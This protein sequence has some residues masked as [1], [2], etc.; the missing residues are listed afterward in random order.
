MRDAP[1]LS[2][3]LTGLLLCVL[4]TPVVSACDAESDPLAVIVAEETRG[5]LALDMGVPA[6]PEMARRAEVADRLDAP[7]ESW[8]SS[9]GRTDAEGRRIRSR[10]YDEALPVLAPALG[11]ARIG[12][13]L[14]RLRR[15]VDAAHELPIST[16]PDEFRD[17]IARAD[18]LAERAREALEDGRGREAL[19]HTVA[20][21]DA[22]RE[23][24][25]RN[26]ALYLVDRAEEAAERARSDGIPGAQRNTRRGSRMALG[27]REALENRDYP[28]AI[29]RA[30][31][32]CHLLGLDIGL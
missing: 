32:A 7:L 1:S 19:R 8:T 15:A 21:S 29:R 27:A 20:G 31:Y 12:E 18:E 9:W 30:Y 17:R 10:S 24:G 2:T 13:E 22:L 23:I 11:E 28:L 6:L 3:P 4:V 25:P 26:V 16:L 5:A 14:D